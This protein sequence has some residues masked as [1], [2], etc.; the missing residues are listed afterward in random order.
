MLN[1]FDP[2][3]HRRATPVADSID[4][5]GTGIATLSS[6]SVFTSKVTCVFGHVGFD[7]PTE[8]VE[9]TSAALELNSA[10][11]WNPCPVPWSGVVGLASHQSAER[12]QRY[13][14]EDQGRP[15]L[16]T[17]T[18]QFRGIHRPIDISERFH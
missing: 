16:Q 5:R 4:P 7:E 17:A 2:P 1:L 3:L 11:N 10:W 12:S 13:D 8:F 15:S 18:R 9:E 6:L 14:N